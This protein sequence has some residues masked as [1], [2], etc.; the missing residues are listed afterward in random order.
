MSILIEIKG[1]INEAGV[2]E[3][4]LPE[5]LPSGEVTVKIEMT[6]IET[7]LWENA[8]WM[9]DE[10]AVYTPPRPRKAGSAHGLIKMAD[11]FDAPLDDFAQY[12]A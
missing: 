4:E 3:I 11:D 1:R 6:E 9:K 2:L 7:S 8:A 12:M 10:H 5:G